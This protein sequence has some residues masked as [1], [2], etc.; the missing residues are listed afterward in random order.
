MMNHSQLNAD[1]L[2][3]KSQSLHLASK[4]IADSMKSGVFKSFF[5]G[6]G[7]EFSGVREYL[8]GDDV[9]SIDWNVTARMGK[10][11]VKQFEEDREL[12]LFL[13]I[14]AS[15]SMQT[16]TSKNSRLY[17][18]FETAAL[19][20][21]ASSYTNSPVGYVVF[22]GDISFSCE[23]KTGKDQVPLLLSK[24]EN[25]LQESQKGNISTPKGSVLDKALKGTTKM[26]R[27][28]SLVLI[29]SD[30][31]VAGY[32]KSLAILGMRHD[33]GALRITDPSDTELPDLGGILFED[34]ETGLTQHL[35]TN[36]VAFRRAW[37]ENGRNSF[38]RWQTEC[39]RRGVYPL[40]IST[41]HDPAQRLQFF[42]SARERK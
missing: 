18:A 25:I 26:L 6:R 36:S 30:F 31:R 19:A 21:F 11:F 13:V 29:V 10:T 22:D 3:R 34:S 40:E 38:E 8:R 37:R 9:R 16:G 42:F 23:P 5:R 33:V 20:A 1:S 7:I 17:T 32:E 2:L 12:V 27:K 28:R 14:D 35:P 41:E 39:T 24:L 15:L 4:T